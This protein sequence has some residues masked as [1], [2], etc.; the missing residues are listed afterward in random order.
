[1]YAMAAAFGDAVSRIPAA[2]LF[3]LLVCLLFIRGFPW[4]QRPNCLLTTL[5]L[6]RQT[7]DSASFEL[8]MS[9]LGVRDVICCVVLSFVRFVLTCCR[10]PVALHASQDPACTLVELDIRSNNLKPNDAKS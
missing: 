7:S 9:A 4:V 8:L 10:V 6:G 1:M 3:H 2:L 5:G